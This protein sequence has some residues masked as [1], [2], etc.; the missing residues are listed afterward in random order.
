MDKRR[1]FVLY[2]QHKKEGKAKDKP[3]MKYKNFRPDYKNIE[4]CAF[5][6]KPKRVPLYEH[7]ISAGMME[8]I[9][10]VKF[11]DCLYS[12]P[13]RYFKEYCRFFYEAGYDAVSFEGCVTGVLPDGGALAHPRPGYIDG[14][15]K[16]KN[17]P[18]DK[19]KDLYIASFK[20]QFDALRK[21]M[22]SG[23][24]AV[25]GVGNGVFENAQDLCGFEGLCVLKYD[26]PEL[27]ADIFAKIGETMYGIWEWFLSEYSDLYCVVRFGDDLGYKSNTMLPAEDIKAHI[28][29]Q[30]KRIIE[31]VHKHKKPFLLH[32]CGNIFGVMDDLIAAGIDAK[33]SNEDQIA[34][35]DVWVEKYGSKIGNFGGIDTDHLVSLEDGALKKLVTE[36]YSS[37]K[38]KNGG[39]AIGSGNSIPDY[40]NLQ[41]YLI[42]LDTV[43]S[44]RGD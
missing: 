11:A 2:L 24:K 35:F 28:I 10:N 23:M 40:V 29:P 7:N 18:F 1:C 30:Y 42:M 43:R 26:E 31:L 15:E 4:D 25:G 3:N 36:T 41:K 34:T 44:L 12:D 20:P 39:F 33:H 13:N 27:Y 5:N 19:I 17:Y 8:R 21:N 37:A 38:K 6:R 22:P 14:V 16:F 9:L 32:S